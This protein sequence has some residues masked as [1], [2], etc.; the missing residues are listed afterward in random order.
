LSRY[1][2]SETQALAGELAKCLKLVA[3]SSMNAEQQT[4]WLHAAVEALEGI[5]ASEVA[6]VSAEVRRSVTRP[7]QIVHEIAKLV[8]ERRSRP[9]GRKTFTA[10]DFYRIAT[11][12]GNTDLAAKWW[13]EA[14]ARGEVN[15]DPKMRAAG[16]A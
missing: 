1:P 14:V 9:V 2:A 15:S 4:V 7:A 12:D 16:D 13:A 10:L 5:R 3:A 6:A 11:E 8:A